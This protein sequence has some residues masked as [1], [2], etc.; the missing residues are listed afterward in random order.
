MS[1]KHQVWTATV[2]SVTWEGA[3]QLNA[4][5]RKRPD[6]GVTVLPT[7]AGRQSAAPPLARLERL[8]WQV[9]VA[10]AATFLGAAALLLVTGL[11]AAVLPASWW[12]RPAGSGA[13]PVVGLA[14][15][16]FYVL[17]GLLAAVT[18][19]EMRRRSRRRWWWQAAVGL[20][21]LG[22]AVPFVVG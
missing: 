14:V 13:S 6:D 11:A 22:I 3:P 19:S 4:G 20:L 21:L 18:A 1:A 5:V 16:P 10:V 2:P 8:L 9:D 12:P 15:L 17:P 7:T